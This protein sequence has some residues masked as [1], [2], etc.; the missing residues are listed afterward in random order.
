MSDF[1]RDQRA[2]RRVGGSGDP[3]DGSDRQDDADASRRVG[4]S[5]DPN[6]DP[7]GGG[8]GSD[9]DPS[10]SDPEPSGETTVG[11][12]TSAI[13]DRVIDPARN[14]VDRVG[15]AVSDFDPDTASGTTDVSPDD[16]TDPKTALGIGAA[17]V[18]TPEPTTSVGGAV[19]GT[20]AAGALAIDAARRSEF[21]VPEREEVQETGELAPGRGNPRSSE[22]GVGEQVGSEVSVPTGGTVDSGE[23]DVPERRESPGEIGVPEAGVAVGRGETIGREDD[24][25][26]ITEE[27]LIVPEDP[28]QEAPSMRE[29]RERDDLTTF[30]RT[31]DRF[32]FPGGEGQGVDEADAAGTLGGV[33]TVDAATQSTF[34]TE[35]GVGSA[36]D[37]LPP[38]GRERDATGILDETAAAP[39]TTTQPDTA[40]GSDEEIVTDTGTDTATDQLAVEQSLGTEQ[41][42]V[43]EEVLAEQ[44]ATPAEQLAETTEEFVEPEVALTEP[45]LAEPTGFEPT[46]TSSTDERD[47][48]R[49]P[50][51]GQE[52]DDP[53]GPLFGVAGDRF[54]SGILG[55]GEALSQAFDRS[56]R[57]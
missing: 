11:R 33:T 9:P 7:S 23:I 52:N 48:P 25:V 56:D 17:G 31:R 3:T 46:G 39:G 22:L 13:N 28:E 32:V 37:P 4:G 20:V 36:T 21:E 8:G 40:F 24:R 14:T 44:V 2:S 12:V 42:V 45:V 18:A 1:R 26:E 19:L 41:T 53:D 34:P 43:T 35:T 51:D 57:L 29:R 55:G 49:M 30:E 47:R 27:D 5:G 50:R 15:D 6:D 16:L 54:G 38:V 10:D